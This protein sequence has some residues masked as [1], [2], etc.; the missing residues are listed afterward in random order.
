MFNV[1]RAA[2]AREGP[3]WGGYHGGIGADRIDTIGPFLQKRV[4][5]DGFPE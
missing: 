2:R 1:W 4:Q 5:S 3:L